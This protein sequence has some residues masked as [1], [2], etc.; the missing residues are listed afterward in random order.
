M[1]CITKFIILIVMIPV[2]VPL[3]ESGEIPQVTDFFQLTSNTA[4]EYDAAWGPDDSNIVYIKEGSFFEL[5]IMDSNG[6]NK[7]TLF[8]QNNWLSHPY[9]GKN[10][11]LYITKDPVP[12]DSHPN[13]WII[14]NDLKNPVQ[15]T[16]NK[17]DLKA[18]SWNNNCTKILFLKRQNLYYEIWT[19][20]ANTSNATG[21]T[22]LQTDIDT[23]SW[24]FDGTKIAFSQDNDIWIMNSDGTNRLNLT[25]DDYNQ[26]GPAWSPDGEW[27][28]FTSDENGDKDIWIMKSDGSEMS[29]LINT[30][31]DQEHPEWS[32]D[33]TKLLYISNQ[34]G[35]ADIW[36]VSLYVPVSLYVQPP[37]TPTPTP[38]YTQ[39]VAD[40]DVK[41]NISRLTILGVAIVLILLTF[42]IRKRIK[43]LKRS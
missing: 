22:Y 38:F 41:E 9:W 3:A 10:G 39:I 42:V 43:G 20:D 16:R 12:R 29:V 32:H 40:E 4:R 18:P 15:L 11:I 8:R 27:I 13:I 1:K 37:L 2:L 14:D 35:N 24:S 7:E 36:A 6:N 31:K 28:A 23:P 34:N 33:G 19:M 26:S 30:S 17:T 25:H 21:L 5:W